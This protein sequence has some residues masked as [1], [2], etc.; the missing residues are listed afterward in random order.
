MRT[1]IVGGVCLLLQVVSIGCSQQGNQGEN[2]GDVTEAVRISKKSPIGKKWAKLGGYSVVGDAT[3]EELD[4]PGG[5][6]RFQSFSNG[7]IVSSDDFGAKYMTHEIFDKWISLRDSTTFDGTNL[8]EFVGPPTQDVKTVGTHQDSEFERGI[9]IQQGDDTWVVYGEIYKKFIDFKGELGLP[10]ADETDNGTDR[11]IQTFEQGEIHWKNTTKPTP[12]WALVGDIFTR[13]DELRSA[14]DPLGAPTSDVEKLPLGRAAR[15]ENG[16]IYSNADAG[17]WEVLGKIQVA[18][19]ASYGGPGGF[20][21]FPTSGDSVTSVSNSHFND[22]QH[23]VIVNHKPNDGNK[24]INVFNEL[25]F[26]LERLQGSDSDCFWGSCGDVDLFA[27][28]TVNSSRDGA[29]IDNVRY[30]SSGDYDRDQVDFTDFHEPLGE[31][32]SALSVDV[33]IKIWDR[34]LTSDNDKLG[35]LTDTFNIDNLW[36]KSLSHDHEDGHAR[37][38]FTVRSQHPF[39]ENADF[40]ST[41]WWSF[42]NFS[43]ATLGY[44]KFADAF[45]DVGEDEA[46]WRHPF[47]KLYFELAFE[48]I[49]EDGNCF[50]MSLMSI[51]SQLGRNGYG[52]PIHD[53]FN[54]TW[55]G[56]DLD[57]NGD[58]HA[59]LYD[60]INIKQGQ[61]LGHLSVFWAIAMFAGGRTHD[62][63]GNFLVSDGFNRAGQYPLIS[64]YDDYWG[65]G[66]HVLRPYAWD[67]VPSDCTQMPGDWCFHVKV[68]DPN[69][70][71]RKHTG[72]APAQEDVIEVLADPFPNVVDDTFSYTGADG[73]VI[74]G[75]DVLGGRWF[76]LP[77][78]L[79]SGP[80]HT[81]FDISLELIDD[82]AVVVAGSTG[83]VHQVADD[84]ERTLFEP[85]LSGPPS[86]WDEFRRDE[87]GMI[88]NV[89]P[90][91]QGNGIG[92]PNTTQMFGTFGRGAT[93]HWDV[94]LRVGQPQGTAYET[95]FESGKMSSYFSIPGT[96]G[97]PD[98]ITASAMGRPERSMSLKIPANSNDK[99]VTWTVAGAD[100]HAY[101]EHTE[102][103]LQPGQELTIK[104][105]N[106]GWDLHYENDGPETTTRI[107]VHAGSDASDVDLGVVRIPSGS[108]DFQFLVPVT[109]LSLSNVVE[110]ND[111]WL[112]APPTV[113]FSAQDFSGRDI[114]QT[115]YGPDEDNWTIYTGPFSY[116]PEGTTTLFFRSLDYAQNLEDPK[117]APFHIDTR[118]PVVHATTAQGQYTRVQSFTVQFAATDPVPGSGLESVLAD[119]D[120]TTVAAG[121]AFDLFWVPL[122]THTLKVKAEDVAGWTT[123]D[124]ASFEIIATIDS[125]PALIRELRR[126]GEIDSDGT[127][128]SLLANAEGAL[129]SYKKGNITSALNQLSA[130]INDAAAQSGKHV[131]ARGATLLIG[132]VKY[133]SAHLG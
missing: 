2:V 108:T 12:A 126:R 31:A 93:Q 39:D 44:Q 28:I 112:L 4:A 106:G 1:K 66:A 19:E 120:G 132:D 21:G 50:G 9:I 46:T 79:Y 101:V 18:Y 110:G 121:D 125:L 10:T 52:E 34:D 63:I 92:A 119:I 86:R 33:L 109:T 64:M 85:N 70:P 35:N 43:T 133:V 65:H 54:D 47:N 69:K 90:I 129:Q 29:V 67:D 62:S 53:Y 78:F 104:L 98:T 37:A 113:T 107:K 87:D 3:S 94:G 59:T 22:F 115:E 118:A 131:S 32:N 48:E 5:I 116:T 17:T 80:Q 45:V 61:Q 77:Y 49:A 122:G 89:A 127:M 55:Q 15:F 11:R 83:A 56:P 6:A 100:K 102:L 73:D 91:L 41:Q 36:G 99:S 75:T 51:D 81:P 30:P 128:K 7:V 25:D 58:A 103:A 84:D 123:S 124:S 114:Q 23:G 13:Y 76:T 88:P 68:A 27:R 105:S 57:R 117:S 111:G 72:E 71:T 97:K 60:A 74:R 40:R 38:R 95:T 14:A 82:I 96:P 8:L 130:L 20:L 24:G 42:E 26:T 16:A